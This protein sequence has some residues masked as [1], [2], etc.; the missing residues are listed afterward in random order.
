[1][2]PDGVSQAYRDAGGSA[3]THVYSCASGAVAILDQPDVRSGQR[4]APGPNRLWSIPV[5]QILGG[6][7]AECSRVAAVAQPPA[8]ML[9]AERR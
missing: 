3:R 8:E 1:M 5:G 4:G 6:K 9:D 2:Q 7:A